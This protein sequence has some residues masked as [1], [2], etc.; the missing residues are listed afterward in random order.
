M[1]KINSSDDLAVIRSKV[2]EA[3]AAHGK[4]LRNNPGLVELVRAERWNG[5]L[6]ATVLGDTV[7]M[8][9]VK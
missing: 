8:M 6:P 2:G 5:V 3:I 4:A 1:R 7:P 9:T